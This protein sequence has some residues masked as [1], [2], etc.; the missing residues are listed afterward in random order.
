[1]ANLAAT[2]STEDV[3]DDD[4]ERYSRKQT[5]LGNGLGDAEED[6]MERLRKR[7][8]IPKQLW[9]GCCCD[10][11]EQMVVVADAEQCPSFVLVLG[12]VVPMRRV[13]VDVV[14]VWL[15]ASSLCVKIVAM[16]RA[17]LRCKTFLLRTPHRARGRQRQRVRYLLHE[18]QSNRLCRK[19]L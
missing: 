7:R 14:C 9:C 18:G 16:D 17:V 13:C 8:R 15:F 4:R 19:R 11:E 1:M 10:D 2:N 3:V 6:D 5:H 12:V